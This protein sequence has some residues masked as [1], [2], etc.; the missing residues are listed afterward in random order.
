MIPPCGTFR[1]KLVLHGSG[2]PW[3][4]VASL[5]QAVEITGDELKDARLVGHFPAV[6]IAGDRITLVARQQELALLAAAFLPIDSDVPPRLR[7][8]D[9]IHMAR[10]GSGGI[11]VSI[12]RDGQLVLAAGAI[13]NV[14]LGSEIQVELFFEGG[15]EAA[16]ER[17]MRRPGDREKSF[18][19]LTAGGQRHVLQSGDASRIGRHDVLVERGYMLGLPGTDECVSITV[20]EAFP[21]D[22][23]VRWASLLDDDGDQTFI[24][25]EPASK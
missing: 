20:E 12:I 13:S 19:A 24:D 8:G 15:A 4:L 18:V 25:W 16:W 14:P 23:A 5:E 11:G 6:D 10:S 7:T 22:V 1:Y 21:Q 9:V 3:R 2:P 17:S